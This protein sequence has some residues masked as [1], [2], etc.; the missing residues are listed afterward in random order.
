MTRL[1]AY[2]RAVARQ[3]APGRRRHRARC[4]LPRRAWEGSHGV[5]TKCPEH[6]TSGCVVG[7]ERW[8]RWA[9]GSALHTKAA[10]YVD[11]GAH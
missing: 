10:R 3:F 9:E 2:L 7:I 4:R 11:A 5:S 6:R 1:C 8:H